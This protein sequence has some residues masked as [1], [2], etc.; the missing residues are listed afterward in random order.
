MVEFIGFEIALVG[1]CAT[2]GN[3]DLS[4]QIYQ[5]IAVAFDSSSIHKPLEACQM[6]FLR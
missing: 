3:K 6:R 4:S 2:R 1:V 5:F